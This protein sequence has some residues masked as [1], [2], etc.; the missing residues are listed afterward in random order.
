VRVPP[1]IWLRAHCAG[2]PTSYPNCVFVDFSENNA[3]GFCSP[4]QLARIGIPGTDFIECLPP[5]YRLGQYAEHH[6]RCPLCCTIGPLPP[7]VVYSLPPSLSSGCTITLTAPVCMTL[8][9]TAEPL[10]HRLIACVLRA[11]DPSPV[12]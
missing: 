2:T 8:I 12:W 6:S 11:C 1:R 5:R 4:A 7:L 10:F 9:I 3:D